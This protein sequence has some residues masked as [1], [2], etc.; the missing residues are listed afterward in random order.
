MNNQRLATVIE[1][2]DDNDSNDKQNYNRT[3]LSNNI[4][5]QTQDKSGIF[6][7]EQPKVKKHEEQ[8]LP[9]LNNTK[10]DYINFF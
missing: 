9:L 2:F 4:N 5:T 10:S 8:Q 1:L 6:S 3:D 7:K